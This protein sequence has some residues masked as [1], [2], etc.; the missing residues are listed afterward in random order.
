MS[1]Y[2]HFANKEELIDLMYSEVAS[3]LYA[4]TGHDSWEDE[5]LALGHQ[6]RAVLLQHPRWIPLLSRPAPAATVAIRE[7]VVRMMTDA[8]QTPELALRVLSS[9]VLVAVGLTLVE[10]TFRD[11]NGESSFGN[12]F[13]RLKTWFENDSS[14]GESPL[15]KVAF[16]KMPRLDLS[17]TFDLSIKALIEG[18]GVPDALLKG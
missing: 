6:M 9:I 16:S 15:A 17:E 5:L 7:R 3:Q 13:N 12:R 4:D 18:M 14:L 1:L 8:G 2:T 10:L 11:P